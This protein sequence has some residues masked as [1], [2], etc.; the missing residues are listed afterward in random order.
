[1]GWH[2]LVRREWAHGQQGDP[3]CEIA[4]KREV[5]DKERWSAKNFIWNI[6]ADKKQTYRILKEL[7][8]LSPLISLP[9]R[10]IPF[11]TGKCVY[12]TLI[13]DFCFKSILFNFFLY[14]VY[15]C[16]TNLT[17]FSSSHETHEQLSLLHIGVKWRLL[18]G[19]KHH[20]ST[21]SPNGNFLIDRRNMC[22]LSK[23]DS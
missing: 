13:L 6:A 17:K 5:A 16:W 23:G 15:V 21:L 9:D 3:E 7:T 1:M 8:F 2:C 18:G 12:I 19:G 14:F 22:S 4:G 20:S 10:Q 11:H